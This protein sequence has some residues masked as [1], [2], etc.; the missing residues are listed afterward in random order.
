MQFALHGH[1]VQ[2]RIVIADAVACKLRANSPEPHAFED[3]YIPRFC[4]CIQCQ[5]G[6]TKCGGEPRH[7]LNHGAGNAVALVCW[8]YAQ[9]EQMDMLRIAAVLHGANYVLSG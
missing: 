5:S 7:M 2:I 4:N 8:S 9:R 1:E 3:G 6:V